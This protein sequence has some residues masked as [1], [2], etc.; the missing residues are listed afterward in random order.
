MNKLGLKLNN[1]NPFK[2]NVTQLKKKLIDHGVLIFKKQKINN[3]KLVNFAN[4]FGKPIIHSFSNKINK[5]PEIMTITKEK[6]DK[7][8]FGGTWHSDSTYLK[9]PPRYTIL[10]PQILPGK[11]LGGTKF[12]CLINSYNFLDDKLKKKLKSIYS[13]NSSKTKLYNYRKVNEN[14]KHKKEIIAFH[15]IVKKISHKAKSLYFSPGHIKS[16]S[17]SKLKI[18]KPKNHKY[19]IDEINRALFRK[20]NIFTHEW[21]KGDLVIWDNYRTLHCPIN[22]F[23]NKKRVMLR[24]SVK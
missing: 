5:Y 2:E 3:R 15:N 14:N 19:I 13:C 20:K 10:Y 23:T 12:S 18:T 22:N 21:E 9:R 11:K 17:T 8:M 4:L 24:V 6:K 1:C 7:K 16:L